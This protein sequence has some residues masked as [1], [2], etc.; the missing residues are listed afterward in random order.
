MDNLR[1]IGI[2]EGKDSVVVA[3]S[4][5]TT[6]VVEK[7]THKR[8]ALRTLSTNEPLPARKSARIKVAELKEPE[9]KDAVEIVLRPESQPASTVTL[10]Q[11]LDANKHTEKLHKPTTLSQVMSL[12][13]AIKAPSARKKRGA[14]TRG[15][16]PRGARKLTLAYH[17][18]KWGPNHFIV[19]V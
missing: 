16:N 6:D 4:C 13:K 3:D 11:E 9:C 2:S 10:K 18:Q 7:P 8:Q 15:K 14:T 12:Q 17:V 5:P 19:L 1:R